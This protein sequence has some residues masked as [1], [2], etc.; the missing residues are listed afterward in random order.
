[1]GDDKPAFI[2]HMLADEVVEERLDGFDE[3]RRLGGELRQRLG[4][5]VGD[6]DILAPELAEELD[7]VVAGNAQ[8]GPGRP[9]VHDE[10]K[11]GRRGR[12]A[13]HQVA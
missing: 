13:V 3:L 2:E 11:N 4:E 9:H 6:A 5:A 12:A 8:G 10:A 1:M 7:V